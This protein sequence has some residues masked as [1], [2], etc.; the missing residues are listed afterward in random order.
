MQSQSKGL[1]E[2]G[3]IITLHRTTATKEPYHLILSAWCH[4]T[5]THEG[6]QHILVAEVLGPG[7]VF[8]WRAAKIARHFGNGVADAMR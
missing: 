4:R 2:I 5:V 7:L 6:C 3:L 8:L 1:D